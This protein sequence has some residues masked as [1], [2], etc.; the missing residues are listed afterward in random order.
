MFKNILTP[1]PINQFSYFL[2]KTAAT[3][4]K[5]INIFLYASFFSLCLASFF[6]QIFKKAFIGDGVKGSI[7]L[8]KFLLIAL[9]VF[10]LSPTHAHA[11]FFSDIADK[12]L[13]MINKNEEVSEETSQTMSVLEPVV[14]EEPSSKVIEGNDASSS[15]T[16]FVTSGSLRLSNEDIDFPTNDTISVY[17]VKKGDSLASVAKLFGVSKNT[18]A[19][20]NDLKSNTLTVGDTLVILPMTGI[21]HVVKKGDTILSIA[22]N[23]KAD[24]DDISKFN[25]VAKDSILTV[26]DIILVPEGEISAP[27]SVTKKVS[28]FITDQI[29]W[30]MRPIQGGRRTQGVHGHNGVDLANKVGTPVL[31]SA[32][33]RVILAKQGG[34]NGGY[35]SMVI[36]LHDN[37]VQTLYAHLSAVY[38]SAGQRVTQGTVIG[39]LGNTGKSTGPHLHFEVRGA[40]NPF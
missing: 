40:I 25:G 1:P 24:A 38:V 13:S 8:H 29:G 9:C 22:K 27:K 4:R 36:I 12:V 31:A 32:G 34:W 18:I 21:K 20:A 5:K 10:V 30:L 35:G 6:Q 14:F 16:L 33:G 7:A 2:K 39:A 11:S 3:L 19:W 28:K 17:E 26:G 23:Y 37:G 15:D